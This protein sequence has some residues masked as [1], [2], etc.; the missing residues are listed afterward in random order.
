MKKIGFL[1]SPP[2]TGGVPPQAARGAVHCVRPLCLARE[3]SLATFP[4]NGGGKA[5]RNV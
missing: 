3:R 5:Q 1:L 2:F 4:V